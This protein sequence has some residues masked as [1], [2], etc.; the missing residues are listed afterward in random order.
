M[1]SRSGNLLAASEWFRKM[2]EKGFE[3]LINEHNELLK[4]RTRMCSALFSP[5]LLLKFVFLVISSNIS[6]SIE[7]PFFYIL[8]VQFGREGSV[9]ELVESLVF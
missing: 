9:E 5:F 2:G 1:E 6:G 8:G 3:R 4:A 7:A